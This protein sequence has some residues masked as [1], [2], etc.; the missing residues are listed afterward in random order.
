MLG[1]EIFV[2][3]RFLDSEIGAPG[4]AS[5]V[6][7]YTE[8]HFAAEAL[9]RRI[10]AAVPEATARDWMEDAPFLRASVH[11]SRVI[12]TLSQSMVFFAVAIPVMALLYISMLARRPQLAILAAMG[13]GVAGLA[14]RSGGG[15]ARRRMTTGG[16]I[17]RATRIERRFGAAPIL[18]GVSLSVSL[19][20]TVALVGPSG[21]GKS[22]LLQI[23][24]L[25]DRPTSGEVHLGRVDAFSLGAVARAR[26]RLTQLGFVFQRSHLL[27]HLTALDNVAL[28]AWRLAADRRVALER[29]ESL[30]DGLGMRNR[31][32]T[33]ARDLSVGEAQRV[34]I[35]RA[36]VNRPRLVL[37]DEPTGALDSASAEQVRAAFTELGA[38]GTA[39]LMVTHDTSLATRFHRV[40]TMRDGWLVDPATT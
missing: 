17:L 29:A 7:A 14:H 38:S 20:E 39:L 18:G 36:L 37:A 24:G 31:L 26:L 34:A 12:G 19:G 27:R 4:A 33:A 11:A 16:E 35:A 3:R 30:L 28:P 9:A 22:T 32:R 2:S 25:L 23:L 10:G 8:D 40:L 13:P 21:P 1:L 15:A 6:F 5:I